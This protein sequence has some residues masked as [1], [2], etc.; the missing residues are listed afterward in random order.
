MTNKD[1]YYNLLRENNGL[2]NE[3]ELGETIGL[4]ENET[5]SLLSQLL[6]EYK[7]TYEPHEACNYRIIKR[8]K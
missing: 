5:Q 3:L 8:S 2:L 4:D 6:C 1:K 7:I